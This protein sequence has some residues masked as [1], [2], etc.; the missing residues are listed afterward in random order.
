MC[1]KNLSRRFYN[2][3]SFGCGATVKICLKQAFLPIA[4]GLVPSLVGQLSYKFY[5]ELTMCPKILSRRFY[6]P[7]SS[8][9]IAT[10]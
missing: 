6:Y 10:V 4:A 1:P 8:G 3:T 7:R 9:C 5:P 2:P